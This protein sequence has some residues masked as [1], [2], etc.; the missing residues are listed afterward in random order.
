MS[1]TAPLLLT[2]LTQAAPW[3]LS[4]RAPDACIQPAE[5]VQRV[6]E[7]L[8]REVFGPD[9]DL[10]IDGVMRELDSEPR[11]RATLTLVDRKGAV[12]GS[13]GVT[14]SDASCRAM[15]A[16]LALVIAVMID[17]MAAMREEPPVAQPE[18]PAPAP[19]A[20][21]P[22]SPT[23][24]PAVPNAHALLLSGAAGLWL[25]PGFHWG[26]VPE[27]QL[28]LSPRFFL[29]VRMPIYPAVPVAAADASGALL[30]V[31]LGIGVGWRSNLS[32]DAWS[33]V[34]SAGLEG[35]AFLASARTALGDRTELL[36]RLDVVGRAGVLRTLGRAWGVQLQ[37]E[38]GLC[39]S[40]P[41]FRLVRADG[42]PEDVSVGAIARIG[43]EVALVLLV[44]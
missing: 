28:G 10:R 38:A 11:W 7:R 35:T 44:R 43:G 34:F 5:L 30:G 19:P 22:A 26:L 2:L 39:P 31:G 32:P 15:D 17:P 13:R 37:A 8:G 1:L 3:G 9:P 18:P 40:P 42:R 27:L 6:E 14:S 24:T 41:N 20:P 29:P 12:K 36:G 21:A 4:W 25:T 16:S 23:V 33:A